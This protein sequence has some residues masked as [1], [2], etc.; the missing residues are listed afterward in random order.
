MTPTCFNG[1]NRS[2]NA[3]STSFSARRRVILWPLMVDCHLDLLWSLPWLPLF[4][5]LFQLKSPPAAADETN[6][7]SVPP[8]LPP[9]KSTLLANAERKPTH[10]LSR[11]FL[12]ESHPSSLCRHFPSPPKIPWIASP[13]NLGLQTNPLYQWHN[14]PSSTA[15][16]T[17]PPQAWQST[18]GPSNVSPP[19]SLPKLQGLQL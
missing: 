13:R 6:A 9:N 18:T 17:S 4:D 7:S 10:S 8:C 14:G 5:V 11:L 1:H 3:R 12:A 2:K 15:V 19:M 16:L